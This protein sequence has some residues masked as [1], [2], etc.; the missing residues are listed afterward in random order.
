MA[1]APAGGCVRK[2]RNPVLDQSYRLGFQ[3]ADTIRA[4]EVE[5][6][7]ALP[8]GDL[9][10]DLRVGEVGQTS[11]GQRFRQE[12]VGQAGVDRDEHACVLDEL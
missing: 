2:A 5:V 8:E 11:G 9:P 10:A 1:P 6:E 12:R 3:P 7:A 4:D